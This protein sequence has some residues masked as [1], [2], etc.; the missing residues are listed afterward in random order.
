M[1][2]RRYTPRFGDDAEIVAAGEHVGDD[3][4]VEGEAVADGEA[5]LHLLL[6]EEAER[7]RDDRLLI[8]EQQ[9]NLAKWLAADA[10]YQAADQAVQTHGG[11][12]LL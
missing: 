6:A 9:A 5:R 10:G 8:T 7:Y 4:G 1:D 12:A 11:K 2:A 3:L